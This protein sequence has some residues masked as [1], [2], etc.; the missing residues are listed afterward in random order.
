MVKG[1]ELA[2]EVW[3]LVGRGPVVYKK[4]QNIILDS[5]R[6]CLGAARAF[7]QFDI[8]ARTAIYD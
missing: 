2:D 6:F 1:G 8:Q 5:V 3:Q 4:N 7:A